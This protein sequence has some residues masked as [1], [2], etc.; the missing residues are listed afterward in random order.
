M[1]VIEGRGVK[2]DSWA[3]GFSSGVIHFAHRGKSEKDLIWKLGKDRDG[4]I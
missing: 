4:G 3:S 2:D 1:Y